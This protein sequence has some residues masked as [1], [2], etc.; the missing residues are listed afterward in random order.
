MKA[1]ALVALSV[2]F[3]G[4]VARAT[5]ECGTAGM[6]QCPSE[7]RCYVPGR[8]CEEIC[9]LSGGGRGG[10]G[11]GGGGLTQQ[12]QLLMRGFQLM[13]N[14]AMSSDPQAKARQEAEEARE[15]ARQRAEAERSRQ[16]K[17]RRFAERK[18]Q[19]LG[20]L[21]GGSGKLS[22]KDDEESP[23]AAPP[24]PQAPDAP[25]TPS[26][27]PAAA[28]RLAFKDDEAAAAPATPQPKQPDPR[29]KNPTFSKGY[30]AASRCFS[31]NSGPACAGSA[32]DKM[33]V[34]LNDY[35]AGYE[36]GRKTAQAALDL[37]AR[38]GEGAAMSGQANNAASDPDANGD[39][40]TQWV[41]AYNRGYFQAAH[42]A[43]RKK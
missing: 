36:V 12:Q 1:V 18:A 22:F 24:S 3:A 26:A 29:F 37:A 4:G 15:K 31:A 17:E 32:A 33:D 43:A 38:K 40:R 23:A 20:Q 7:W 11:S 19:I 39:C 14:S 34:C 10:S 6:C 16:E 28:T 13:L 8:S 9:G 30:D 35:R 2:M 25:E 27:A 41:E 21:S 42:S 5:P